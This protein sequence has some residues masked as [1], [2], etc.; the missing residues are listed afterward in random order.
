MTWAEIVV[1]IKK[2]TNYTARTGRS[3]VDIASLALL[4]SL[5]EL[6]KTN[7]GTIIVA[8]NAIGPAIITGVSTSGSPIVTGLTGHAFKTGDIVTVDKGFAS[9]SQTVLTVTSTTV[10]VGNNANATTSG[11]TMAL[12]SSIGA[13]IDCKGFNS[14]AIDCIIVGT[15]AWDISLQGA[16]ISGGTFINQFEGT[17]IK[18][19]GITASQGFLFPIGDPYAKIVATEISGTSSLTVTVVPFNS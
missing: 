9:G 13:E 17:Q 6:A 8:H 11:L 18:V 2:L 4:N 1:E 16:S 12:T 14:L 7:K 10:T 5:Y 19:S 3:E 15:G